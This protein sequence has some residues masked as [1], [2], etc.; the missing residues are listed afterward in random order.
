MRGKDETFRTSPVGRRQRME[1][2]FRGSTLRRGKGTTLLFEREN[3]EKTAALLHSQGL[4]R[5]V[6]RDGTQISSGLFTC[7]QRCSEEGSR[8]LG[9]QCLGKIS[10]TKRRQGNKR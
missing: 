2:A 1:I 9:N 7:H 4:P 8:V 5:A 10:I 6:D 3:L